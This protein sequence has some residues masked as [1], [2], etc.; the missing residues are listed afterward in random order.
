MNCDAESECIVHKFHPASKCYI[1]LFAFAEIVSVVADELNKI[2][3]EAIVMIQKDVKGEFFYPVPQNVPRNSS[4]YP[5][6]LHFDAEY[7]EKYIEWVNIQD[8]S[9]NEIFSQVRDYINLWHLSEATKFTLV[10]NDKTNVIP[11]KGAKY[12]L[13]ACFSKPTP[14][15]PNPLTVARVYFTVIVPVLL[16]KY[17]PVKVIYRFEGTR[18]QYHANGKL[19]IRSKDF[20]RYFID[21]ILQRKLVFY[22]K[23]FECRHPSF[24]VDPQ[25]SE[26]MQ[27]EAN[28]GKLGAEWSTIK[29]EAVESQSDDDEEII[30]PHRNLRVS[31]KVS[32]M[33]SV[34]LFSGIQS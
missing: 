11:R 18:T 10:V 13:D 2:I 4:Q 21:S 31:D 25:N 8:F 27:K 20:Q 33:S 19:E 15:C 26:E 7:K 5:A 32:I 22:T 30:I 6:F 29:N 23:I 3:T 28:K 34:V 9:V 14:A 16:P 24:K 17:Y 12:F 1:N